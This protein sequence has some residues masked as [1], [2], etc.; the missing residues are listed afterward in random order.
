VV[1]VGHGP[2]VVGKRL[3]PWL[4]TQTVVRLK[5][6]L[7]PNV[8]DW[9]SRT[10][11]VCGSNPSFWLQRERGQ[12]PETAEFWWLGDAKKY[13]DKLRVGRRASQHWFENWQRYLGP[14]SFRKPSTGLLAVFCAMEFL[15]P[16]EIGL[17]GF[18]MVLHPEEPTSKWFHP[19]GQYLYS[20]DAR[21]EHRCLMDLG[22][23]ITEL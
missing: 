1:I 5:W 4:D 9:G 16:K 2:S 20:H 8:E 10:D 23:K 18:D 22:V 7:R 14:E 15:Q 11:Y 17:L 6:A 21:A 19:R 12:A 3:G 13:P